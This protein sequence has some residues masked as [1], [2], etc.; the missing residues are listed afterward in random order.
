VNPILPDTH[1][2]GGYTIDEVVRAHGA[3][4]ARRDRRHVDGRARARPAEAQRRVAEVVVLARAADGELA[5]IATAYVA[6]LAGTDRPYW[7]YRT[8][9]R[10]AHRA[11]WAIAPRM[12]D[13]RSPRLRAHDHSAESARHRARRREPRA[14]APGDARGESRAR[15]SRCSARTPRVA[16]SGACTSTAR[17][18]TSRR[19]A[20]ERLTGRGVCCAAATSGGRTRER[21]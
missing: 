2:P 5:G 7:H 14:D 17:C 21:P 6:P 18:P 10:P 3:A 16:T 19:I 9:V 20:S 4:R 11:V 8:F 1:L 15:A 13:T 12:F